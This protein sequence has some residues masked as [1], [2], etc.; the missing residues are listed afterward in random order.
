MGLLTLPFRLPLLPVQGVVRLAQLIQ[1]QAE[2][3]LTDPAAVARQLEDAEQA[4]AAGQ[5]SDEELA[6]AEEAAISRILAVPDRAGRAGSE[7]G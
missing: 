1:E 7:E 4:R 2:R 5:L 6:E 3:E